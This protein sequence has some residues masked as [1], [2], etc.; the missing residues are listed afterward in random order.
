MKRLTL[1]DAQI[2]SRL[3]ML[4]RL[5]GQA[6]HTED[7]KTLNVTLQRLIEEQVQRDLEREDA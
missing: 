3:Q 5:I 4:E 2:E 1:T 6:R 7:L